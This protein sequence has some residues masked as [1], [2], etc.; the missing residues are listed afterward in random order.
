MTTTVPTVW[1]SAF[2]ANTLATN[3]TQS[4]PQ[5][6][7]LK[8]GNILVVWQ[9][10]TNGPGPSI[11]VM[12]RL[13]DPKG[14][15][16]GFPFQVNTDVVNW[17]E[18]GPK[19]VAMPDGGYVIA[20]GSFNQAIGG[21]IGIERHA[22][23]GSLR[24]SDIITDPNSSLSKWEIT[25]DP[26]GNYTIAYERQ[27]FLGNIDIFTVTYN[28]VNNARGPERNAA[29]N[30]DED[31]FLGGVAAFA[32]GHI[33]TLDDEVDFNVFLEHA[34][35]A[36]FTVVDPAI[37]IVRN[38]QIDGEAAASIFGKVE[39]FVENIVVLTGGQFVM[40]YRID[41][42]D[43]N[44]GLWFRIG[45]SE[46]G[47]IANRRSVRLDS[48][49]ELSGDLVALKDGGF[50]VAFYD[51]LTNQL[52]GRRYDSTGTPIGD[53]LNI[54]ENVPADGFDVSHM[55]L[56]EDGRI[57]VPF[58]N[59][60]GDISL[61]ILDPRETIIHGTAAD[62]VITGQV[63]G[64]QLFG[65]G[66]SDT[67]LGHDGDDELD[68]GLGFDTLKGGLGSDTYVLSTLSLKQVGTGFPIFVLVYDDVIEQ[69]GEGVN[70]IVKVG[71]IGNV[72]S[73]TLPANVETGIVSG[74]DP[75]NDSFSL[76][77][78]EL[79]NNL[80][81]NAAANTLSGAAGN[82]TLFGNDG[83]DTL[84]GG[85]GSD[86]LVGGDGDDTLLGNGGSGDEFS[87]THDTFNGGNGSDTIYAKPGDVIQGG[88]DRD[89]LYLVNSNP[90]SINLGTTSIEWIQSDFGN[91]TIDGSAQTVGIEVYSDGG[92]DTII[93]SA[94]NDI[95][96]AGSGSDTV[97]GGEGDDVI[98]GDIGADSLSGG[99]GNDLFFIDSE[100]TFIDG[101]AGA[102]AAYITFGSGMSINLAATHLEWVADFVGGN[103]V[104]DG[105][106]ASANL[107][108]YAEGGTDFVIGGSGAD[109][110]W[111]GSGNDIM[112]G[113]SN[114][115]VL[116]GQGGADRLTG[117]I[118]IDS[119]YGN[120]GNGGD[121]V[122]DTFV[123]G[124][125]WGTDFVF[126]FEHNVDK[127]DM[128]AVSGLND[129]SQLTLT[130]T[131]DGHCYVSFGGNLIAVANHT[132]ANL[133]ASDF[134]L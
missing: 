75:A 4:V 71:R 96:W 36:E 12:G 81:G 110:L 48:S 46:N 31:D 129:F 56:T 64:T 17:D 115:D 74:S 98:V 41:D 25:V 126:D 128:T 27:K 80:T 100:D 130:N 120:A 49:G 20:Y 77:G 87:A 60:A 47:G 125:D 37:G 93:G 54:A 21:F 107:E 44:D 62:E 63:S 102:D 39:A 42:F 3:G 70:D 72:S 114:N 24:F 65:E 131:S 23:D 79:S 84:F 14:T 40:L 76:F 108:I 10:T 89:F 30:S 109:F 99:S 91:D 92:N 58:R 95:I 111:G 51:D 29:Q 38:V 7:G 105:T 13:F 52:V 121:S 104:I 53:F 1:K 43:G 94:F 123:F 15:P 28:Q 61:V 133:T 103:D 122:Q 5:A 67:L 134:L 82:D 69:P 116:V 85:V 16:L 50:F 83:N 59:G 127:I 97:T 2:T 112:A 18:T 34:Q 9:D 35:T 55:S 6:I 86:T 117:G 132:T 118:G 22:A 101:G 124:D 90:V 73:Y 45:S 33:V 26:A 113:N 57:L 66:G 119:L 78:N 88:A 8:N 32:N 11:D 68:G 19:I 106:G